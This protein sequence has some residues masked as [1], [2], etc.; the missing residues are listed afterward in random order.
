MAAV[1]FAPM[2]VDYPAVNAIRFHLDIG[3]R[4][5]IV[6]HR[7]AVCR[8]FQTRDLRIPTHPF[9]GVLSVDLDHIEI[10]VRE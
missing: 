5:V 6:E 8:H 3:P 1:P 10:T 7:H 4:Y 9:I 2:S